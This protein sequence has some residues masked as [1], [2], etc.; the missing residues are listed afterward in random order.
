MKKTD[1]GIKGRAMC[2]G[3][4]TGE[5]YVSKPDESDALKEPTPP[6]PTNPA[7]TREK[8]IHEVIQSCLTD[9]LYG[10]VSKF[11]DALIAERADRDRW[12]SARDE[13]ERQYQVKVDQLE[14]FRCEIHRQKER[15]EKAAAER[16]QLRAVVSAI[17][18][19][20]AHLTITGPFVTNYEIRD[21]F[22]NEL[23]AAR[24]ALKGPN[25]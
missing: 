2:C 21:Y 3:Y 15:V 24:D 13:C 23:A 1:C 22:R 14:S 5:I 11:S 9:T 12:K 4:D 19:R 7:K 8:T 16:D 18:Q 6:E 17:V 20:F 25:Q 10:T